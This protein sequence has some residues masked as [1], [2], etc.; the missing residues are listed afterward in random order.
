[1]GQETHF[2]HTNLYT[3]HP[4]WYLKL[5]QIIVCLLNMPEWSIISGQNHW[6]SPKESFLRLCGG[7]SM[8]RLRSPRSFR[9]TGFSHTDKCMVGLKKNTLSSPVHTTHL[10][11]RERC[12]HAFIHAGAQQT[13][14]GLLTTWLRSPDDEKQS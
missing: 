12:C 6:V 8:I 11:K 9:S 14:C 10:H 1:M 7:S 2:L 4:K 3:M 13:V 5:F